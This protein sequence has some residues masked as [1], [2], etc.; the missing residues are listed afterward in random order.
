VPLFNFLFLFAGA[1]GDDDDEE[2]VVVV[3]V[4]VDD[5]D[6]EDTYDEEG[7]D[8]SLS[9]VFFSIMKFHINGSAIL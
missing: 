2:V 8:L 4:V 5:G 1:G 3:V 6:V 9:S 7:D